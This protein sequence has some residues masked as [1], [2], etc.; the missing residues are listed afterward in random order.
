MLRFP[1]A[2]MSGLILGLTILVL[3]LPLLMIWI[4]T[5]DGAPGLMWIPALFVAAIYLFVWLYMRPSAFEVSDDSLDVVWPVR[6]LSVPMADIT[7]VELLGGRDFRSRY[8]YGMRIGA[9]GLWGGFGLLKMKSV[10]FRF[11]ISRMDDYVILWR[12]ADRPLLITPAK[13]RAFVE[14]L[15]GRRPG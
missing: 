7:K 6:R 13:P 10:T 9:G 11:Y 12:R 4:A 1:L 15:E 14:L 3:P 8:G 2:P 5:R